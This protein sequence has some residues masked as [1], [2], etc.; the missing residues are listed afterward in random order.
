MD[1]QVI[2]VH[3]FQRRPIHSPI[4]GWKNLTSNLWCLPYWTGCAV[5]HFSLDLG[6]TCVTEKGLGHLVQSCPDVQ[7]R[8]LRRALH[9]LSPVAWLLSSFPF[10]LQ[11]R[12][13]FWT[14]WVAVAQRF[15][16]HCQSGCNNGAALLSLRLAYVFFIRFSKCGLMCGSW[17]VK[18]RRI[19]LE[20]WNSTRF[21]TFL[22]WWR[23]ICMI[24]NLRA[25][26]QSYEL[27]HQDCFFRAQFYK[28]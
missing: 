22:R 9:E 17:F 3:T 5:T 23:C 28:V 13:I 14:G 25:R 7:V 12:E 18:Q 24:A 19:E 4:S 10:F 2:S 11:Q 21:R 16:A 20:R 1:Q 6:G 27:Y 15:G 8:C 26:C